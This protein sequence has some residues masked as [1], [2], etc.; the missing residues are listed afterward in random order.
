M[1]HSQRS[2]FSHQGFIELFLAA[3]N[4]WKERNVLIFQGIEPS[5]TSWLANLKS[6]LGLHLIRFRESDRPLVQSWIDHL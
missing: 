4:I 3:W 6:D 2:S 1:L 5:V